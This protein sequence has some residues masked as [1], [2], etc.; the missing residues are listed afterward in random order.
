[1]VSIGPD[2]DMLASSKAAA[3]IVVDRGIF[4]IMF[5]HYVLIISELWVSPKWN[6]ES[7]TVRV[8]I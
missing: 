7:R 3:H 4:K 2:P 1:M 6:A 8:D 5:N